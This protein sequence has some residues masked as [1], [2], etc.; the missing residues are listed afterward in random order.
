M[1]NGVTERARGCRWGGGESHFCNASGV[2]TVGEGRAERRREQTERVLK[3]GQ[4]EGG[5]R[6]TE[7]DQW[8][9]RGGQ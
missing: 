3:D 6:L 9:E 5:D 1:T 2:V 8:T 4:T 7:R